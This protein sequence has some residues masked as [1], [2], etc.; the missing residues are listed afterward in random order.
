[1]ATEDEADAAV[2]VVT[3]SSEPSTAAARSSELPPSAC[4][5]VQTSKPPTVLVGDEETP[6][7]SDGLEAVESPGF[8][9][10][11]SVFRNPSNIVFLG[12]GELVASAA[13]DENLERLF[14]L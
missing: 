2:A 8:D 11:L 12:F 10:R 7:T 6:N 4:D 5:R 1:M 14:S 13:G 9:L 3:V